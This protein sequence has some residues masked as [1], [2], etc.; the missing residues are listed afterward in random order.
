MGPPCHADIS[1][2]P[3][4]GARRNDS[5]AASQ[6]AFWLIPSDGFTGPLAEVGVAAIGSIGMVGAFVGPYVF[7]LARDHTGSYAVGRCDCVEARHA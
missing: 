2:G 6:A 7:G 5:K 1:T 3:S 4:V